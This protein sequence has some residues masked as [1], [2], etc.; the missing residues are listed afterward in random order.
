M[1]APRPRRPSAP[2]FTLLE[3][4]LAVSIFSIVLLAIHLVFYGAVRLRNKTAAEIEGAL[5][6]QQTFTLL[7]R[8]L[9]NLVLPGGILLGALQTTPTTGL[10]LGQTGPA[11]LA[12]L[13]GDLPGQSSPDFYTTTAAIDDAYPWG[14][15]QRVSYFLADSTNQTIGRDLFRSVTRNLLPTL[16]EQ[17]EEQWLMAGVESIFFYYYDGQRWADTWDSATQTNQ[18]PGAIKVAIQ[19]ASTETVLSTGL[20]SRAPIELVVPILVRAG[21]NQT[22]QTGGG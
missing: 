14:E 5:P 22:Q 2:G 10:Q 3:V 18:L 1:T 4:L 16:E 21:T 13:A 8:D 7:R 20:S 11:P 9:S 17:P 19:L 15:V 6:L 12:T